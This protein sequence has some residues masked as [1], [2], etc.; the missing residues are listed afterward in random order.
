MGNYEKALEFLKEKY[1]ESEYFK[2]KPW[3]KEYRLNH[4]IRSANIAR[5]IASQE[6]MNEEAL[7][8][9]SLLHDIAY[10]LDF[11]CKEDIINH[12]R[13]GAKLARPFL[14]S[15]GYSKEIV[16]NI[17]YGIAFH[18]DEQAGYD[19]TLNPFS[20]TIVAADH[21]DRFDVYRI[22]DNMEHVHFDKISLE[23]KMMYVS[24]QLRQLK[25]AKAKNFMTNTANKMWQDKIAF[26]IKFF[27][28]LFKQLQNSN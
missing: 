26:Q 7:A 18:V 14:E 15:L 4:C 5:E 6:G 9:G 23:E 3:S 20:A 24:R 12:G 11:T 17:C 27:N 21:I 22:Y 10:A 1:S 13:N 2:R 19:A 8:V 16:D 28:R 25:R